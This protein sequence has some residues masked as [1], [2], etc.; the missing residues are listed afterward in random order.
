V[1]AGS[2][3]FCQL[4][5]LAIPCLSERART[6]SGMEPLA[7]TRPDWHRSTLAKA[8]ICPALWMGSRQIDAFASRLEL[9]TTGWLH[10]WDRA[11]QSTVSGSFWNTPKLKRG[12]SAACACFSSA[13][14]GRRLLFGFLSGEVT[15]W[16]IE[17]RMRN[18]RPRRGG[19]PEGAQGRCG[20][21]D[22]GR[23]QAPCRRHPGRGD[24]GLQAR[25]A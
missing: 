5:L 7:E 23:G 2:N 4:L 6:A 3:L 14:M 12:G 16:R 13:A 15:P 24:R 11:S 10:P 22:K 18:P 17:S 1:P 19:S 25:S 20:L 21:P 9:Q 8:S